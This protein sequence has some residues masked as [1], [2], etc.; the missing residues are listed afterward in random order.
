MHPPPSLSELGQDLLEV[1]PARTAFALSLPFALLTAYFALA[2]GGVWWA[3]LVCP[4]LISFFTYG[5]VSHDLVHRNLKLPTWLN[6]SLLTIIELLALRSGHAYRTSHLNHHAHFPHDDD[7]EGAAA[8]MTIPQAL[9]EGMTIQYRIWIWAVRKDSPHRQ[10]ILIEG[11]A[12]LAIILAAFALLPW[13]VSPTIYV[14]MM[15]VGSWINPLVTVV[16][17]HNA[18][19][20]ERLRQTRL[21]RGKVLS[22][23]ALEHLYHLEHHLYPQVPHQNWPKLANRLDPY[24]EK[25]HL[26]PIK[27]LF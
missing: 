26:A 21:F 20:T 8:R 22:C 27:L 11:L 3:A 17:P 6:E 23:L 15:I 2:A 4:I 14:V 13:T 12:T 16:I 18:S 5:S 24:F 19:A 7:I 9:R 1:S 25:S 10:L